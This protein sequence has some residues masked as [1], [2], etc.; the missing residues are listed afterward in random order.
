METVKR[1]RFVAWV[2]DYYD[3]AIRE[4]GHRSVLVRNTT[5]LERVK[6]KKSSPL[7]FTA[8]VEIKPDGASPGLQSSESISLKQDLK[9]TVTDNRCKRHLRFFVSR[10]LSCIP[11]ASQNDSGRWGYAVVD[12]DGFDGQCCARWNNKDRTSP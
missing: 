3:R 4:A 2:P 10:W 1:C 12:I 8:T 5:P 9:R 11:R 7:S 6:V